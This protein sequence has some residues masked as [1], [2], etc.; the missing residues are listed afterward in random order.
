MLPWC[1]RFMTP[2]CFLQEGVPLFQKN[3]GRW[4]FTLEESKDGKD[5]ELDVAVGRFLDS[6]LIKADVQPLYVRLL[7]KVRF[8]AY[9]CLLTSAHSCTVIL[10]SVT[11]KSLVSA[12]NTSLFGEECPE[13]H[14]L[15]GVSAMSCQ[16]QKVYSAAT[17]V[18]REYLHGVHEHEC[19]RA[20]ASAAAGAASGS[21]A[22]RQCRSAVSNHR[23][24]P[25][26]HAQR[27]SRC[28]GHRSILLEV[29]T[30]LDALAHDIFFPF[31]DWDVQISAGH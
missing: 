10:A 1:L 2:I 19:G 5:I 4:E 7:I 31:A 27:G 20:G 24:P 6:S 22:W 13:I 3:E 15:T 11:C 18:T 29:C 12:C 8:T 23:K 21:E 28:E 26:H 17:C 25:S 16:A 14:V 30:H 9:V